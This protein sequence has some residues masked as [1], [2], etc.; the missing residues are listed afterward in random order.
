[1]YLVGA[2]KTGILTAH[3]P[4]SL[5]PLVGNVQYWSL[6]N[7][8]NVI[9]AIKNFIFYFFYFFGG[10]AFHKIVLCKVSTN[11]SE[12]LSKNYL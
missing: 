4:K 2:G 9:L 5:R 3:A 1:M 7:L 11:Y 10:G 12:G 8:T 6:W